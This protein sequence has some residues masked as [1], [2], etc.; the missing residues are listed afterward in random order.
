[1]AGPDLEWNALT[2]PSTKAGIPDLPGW[3]GKAADGQ[4]VAS[5]VYLVHISAGKF[6]KILKVIVIK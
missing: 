1:M 2:T 3:N 6:R 4:Y 5:G